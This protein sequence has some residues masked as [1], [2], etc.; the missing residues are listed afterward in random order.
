MQDAA[1]SRYGDGRVMGC[2]VAS[3]NFGVNYVEVSHERVTL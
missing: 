3:A 1:P 2:S